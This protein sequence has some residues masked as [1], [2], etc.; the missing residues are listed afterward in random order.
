MQ[1]YSRTDLGTVG[2]RHTRDGD[3]ALPTC[4][5][6][7]ATKNRP[8]ALGRCLQGLSEQSHHDFRVVV[9]DDGSDEPMEAVVERFPTL[10]ATVVRPTDGAGPAAA[11][12]AGVAA[13]HG[14]Y[15]VFIDDDVLPDR[16]FIATHLETV[17]QEHE[18]GRPIVSFGPFVQPGDWPDPTPWNLWEA[19]QARKE[20]DAMLRGDYEPSWRQ[21]HTGNN[22]VPVASFRAVGGFDTDFTRAEDDELA[23]RLRDAGC[24]F[25]FAPAAIA[26]HYS[27]R[28]LEAWLRIPRA[29]AHFDVQIDRLHPHM[30]YLAAKKRELDDRKLPLRVARRVFAR[31]R[32]TL[33][34]QASVAAARL[35]QR[36]G[37]DDLATAALSVAY[38]L[39]YVDALRAAEAAP[40]EEGH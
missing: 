40:A 28:S 8:A 20:A 2:V 14:E 15:V 38:D 13:S 26:W 22:C 24:D 10:A 25:R 31:R 4:D 39:S 33:G 1:R 23:L 37:R 21:F 3:V 35:V 27:N 9:V 30:G 5:V 36:A 18:P 7:I 32:T 6:V 34:V 11:R 19:K 12:N 16:H 29:Y 17:A